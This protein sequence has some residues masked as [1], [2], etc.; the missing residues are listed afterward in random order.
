MRIKYKSEPIQT[1]KQ[2]F[3]FHSNLSLLAFTLNFIHY[4]PTIQPFELLCHLSLTLAATGR[5]PFLFKQ[6]NTASLSRQHR[7]GLWRPCVPPLPE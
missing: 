3:S 5:I 2:K 4:A 1:N 6:A 7:V